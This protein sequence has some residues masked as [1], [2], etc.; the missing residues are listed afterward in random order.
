MRDHMSGNC[1]PA[2]LASK[3]KSQWL[4]SC[5]SKIKKSNNCLEQSRNWERT[6]V[7][8][9]GLFRQFIILEYNILLIKLN[10]K[11]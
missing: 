11:L 7:F 10:T 1:A 9:W 5:H 2:K 4:P 8:H 6:G 3:I